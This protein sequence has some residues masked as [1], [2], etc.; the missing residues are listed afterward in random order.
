MPTAYQTRLASWIAADPDNIAGF[1]NVKAKLDFLA[2]ILYKEYL[3]TVAGT[4][5]EFPYRLAKWLNSATAEDQMKLMFL[6]LDHLF[7]VGK[8]EFV[9]MYLTAYSQ[10]IAQWILVGENIAVADPSAP[11]KVKDALA[12]TLF[13]AVTESFNIGDF[14]RINSIQGVD[15]RFFWEP[16]LKINWDPNQ[17]VRNAMQGKTRIVLLEDFVGS[18][19]Q[20]RRA[21]EEA[22]SL[23]N[24]PAVLLCPL[25]ICPDGADLARD[26][27][28]RFHNLTY[29]PVLELAPHHFVRPT[30]GPAEPKLFREIRDLVTALHPTVKGTTAWAQDYGP[31]GYGGKGGTGALI[32]KF[33][34][35][36]DNT[37]PLIHHQSDTWEPLF[38]RV[39]REVL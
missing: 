33:D 30:P 27:E 3:P 4:H 9:S 25:I 35:C 11:Q 32:V 23:P 19:S 13:T 5:G 16:A 8:S 37:L 17:F 21:V 34:N 38:F 24:N 36:P 26:L 2:E 14:I 6:L 12:S 7:F 1:R 15:I 22:C 10:H 18:G 31:F 29:R 28:A 20:M 39:S